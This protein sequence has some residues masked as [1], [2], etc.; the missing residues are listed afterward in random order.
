MG[1]SISFLN[2]TKGFDPIRQLKKKIPAIIV[3]RQTCAKLTTVITG[4]SQFLALRIRISPST[5][6]QILH[7]RKLPSWPSQKQLSKYFTSNVRLLCCQAY[8]YSNRWL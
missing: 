8:L 2:S 5:Q 4:A 6:C 7:K 3:A 1:A